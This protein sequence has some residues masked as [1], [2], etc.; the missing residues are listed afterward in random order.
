[1]YHII[2]LCIASQQILPLHNINGHLKNTTCI[3][4]WYCCD[5]SSKYIQ[6]T[7][8]NHKGYQVSIHLN[9]NLFYNYMDTIAEELT[10]LYKRI[11]NGKFLDIGGTGNKKS[12]MDNVYK[13]FKHFAGPLDYWLLD[14]DE[15]VSTLRNGIMCNIENCLKIND[16]SFDVTFSH[17]VLEHIKRPEKAFDTIARITKKMD[18]R[19]T[20]Y[21]GHII[22]TPCPSICID[23]HIKH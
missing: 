15:S 22:F 23:F 5:K 21:L 20:C 6:D 3:S 16:E 2:A 12:M 13:K 18:C 8:Y 9:K 19:S 11:S 4:S 17:T 7:N 10:H 1:M 14:I